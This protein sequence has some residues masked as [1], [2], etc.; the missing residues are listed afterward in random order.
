MQKL[1]IKLKTEIKTAT[2]WIALA[3][4]IVTAAG[5][6]LAN[7]NPKFVFLQL[8]FAII[9]VSILPGVAGV[10]FSVPLASIV[11]WLDN[12]IFNFR[13]KNKIRYFTNE[14]FKEKG[15]YLNYTKYNLWYTI[16]IIFFIL[17]TTPNIF[18]TAE[19]NLPGLTIITSFL[20][21]IFGSGINLAI[22]L[23]KMKSIF[24]E[25]KQ[26]GSI[27]NFGSLYRTKLNFSLGFLQIIYFIYAASHEA[28]F[29]AFLISLGISMMIF[30]A[31][32]L[33]SYHFLQ[34]HHIQRL[35]NQFDKKNGKYFLPDF[36]GCP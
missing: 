34:K 33:F 16:G 27:I 30:F 11:L 4:G 7:S 31:S 36:K 15:S 10:A 13:K 14:Q 28:N 6:V 22:S 25:N 5:I 9:V 12:N 20:A 2:F 29:V 17:R 3:F 32:S 8:P 26:D 19:P 18:T 1:I 35:L 21:I 23:I 24:C